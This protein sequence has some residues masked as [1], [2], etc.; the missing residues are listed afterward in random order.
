MKRIFINKR[1]F[2]LNDYKKFDKQNR[3]VFLIEDQNCDDM[4]ELFF[5]RILN[6]IKEKKHFPIIRLADGE[7]QYLLGTNELNF[8][9][10]KIKLVYHIFNQYYEKLF[11]K[12]FEVKSRTYTSIYGTGFARSNDVKKSKID[13]IKKY[14]ISLQNISKKGILAIYTIIKPEFYTEQYMPNLEQ[15]FQKNNININ[16]ENYVPFYFVYILLTNKKYKSIYENKN[17]HLIT[18]FDKTSKSK[19]EKT[20]KL[21]NVKNITW[22]RLS[23]D[24]VLYDLI[25]I[26]KINKNVDVVFVGGGLG[27]ANIFNQL[28]NFPALIIDAGYIFETWKE[29]ILVKE[30]NYCKT[31]D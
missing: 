4:L 1:P 16:I 10:P 30:R 23:E 5:K 26:K 9:K 19:I 20:L 27:K 14:S 31:H 13:I 8:R 28:D 3:K 21:Y 2:K 7:F 18:S 29:P 25:D 15:F 17:V 11:N 22:T 6:V 24:N 12:R